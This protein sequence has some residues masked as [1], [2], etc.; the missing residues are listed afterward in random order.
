[1]RKPHHIRVVKNDD[2]KTLMFE[3][4]V[5]QQVTIKIIDEGFLAKT[6]CMNSS[7]H[8]APNNDI[9][10]EFFQRLP[11]FVANQLHDNTMFE[12]LKVTKY[13]KM[14]LNPERAANI[15]AHTRLKLWRRY[16]GN[17]YSKL[18]YA[19]VK[20]Q[21]SKEEWV[22]IRRFPK[23]NNFQNIR[24]TIQDYPFLKNDLVKYFACGN[25]INYGRCDNGNWRQS[26]VGSG[27]PTR[28]ANITIDKARQ[29]VSN[30]CIF[31]W[32]HISRPITNQSELRFWK[33][34]F[35]SVRYRNQP[36]EFM[37]SI[38]NLISRTTPQ[39]WRKLL[40]LIRKH[41]R[42]KKSKNY[43]YAA[44]ME[45]ADFLVAH[46]DTIRRSL[47]NIYQGSIDWHNRPDR[48]DNRRTKP[49]YADETPCK[50]PPINLPD[51]PHITFVDTVGMLRQEGVRMHH[52]VAS[53]DDEC[54]SGLSFIFHTEYEGEQATT[55]V[56]YNGMI[57]QSYGPCNRVNK[58]SEYARWKLTEWAVPL[59]ITPEIIH[60]DPEIYRR[61]LIG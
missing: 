36:T 48:W 8:Y 21:F 25:I 38:G 49:K 47:I 32:Q 55:Q 43:I 13:K 14:E 10:Y 29:D 18:I 12:N 26:I 11:T 58:A 7:K 54:V 61:E 41:Y 40:F 59:R 44:S 1:M 9:S 28:V 4:G 30:L 39:E 2:E 24:R 27:K 45:V 5:G 15:T 42:V 23:T 3:N 56:L 20:S 50:A 52:C 6:V 53:F 35:E 51:D 16:F 34:F 22:I 17:R 37:T 46:P 33:Q 57:G 19:F 31:P 60:P